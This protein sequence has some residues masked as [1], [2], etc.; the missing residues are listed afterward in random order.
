[1]LEKSQVFRSEDI[2][3][4][5][6]ISV[7]VCDCPFIAAIRNSAKVWTRYTEYTISE[8]NVGDKNLRLRYERYIQSGLILTNQPI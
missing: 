1:M 8:S 3:V 4:S 2:L 5:Q 7:V 6:M